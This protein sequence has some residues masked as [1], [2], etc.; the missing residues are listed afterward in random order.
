M[1]SRSLLQHAGFSA[2]KTTGV[3]FPLADCI[4]P[5]GIMEASHEW[6]RVFGSVEV[7]FSY[8]LN[9]KYVVSYYLVSKQ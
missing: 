8:V 7:D 6:E 1:S 4:T 2:G 9:L 3:F 5:S